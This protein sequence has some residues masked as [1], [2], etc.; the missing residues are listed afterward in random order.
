MCCLWCSLLPETVC[1]TLSAGSCQVLRD[2]SSQDA[3]FKANTLS[4][5]VRCTM[6]CWVVPTPMCD[7]VH[8]GRHYVEGV[9]CAQQKETGGCFTTGNVL[10][11]SL[12]A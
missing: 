9:G 11:C 12:R 10:A 5:I 3:V 1:C 6:G 4:G 2:S 8:T 7:Q